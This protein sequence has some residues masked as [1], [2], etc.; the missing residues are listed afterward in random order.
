MALGMSLG[1][2]FGLLSRFALI[3]FALWCAFPAFARQEGAWRPRVAWEGD[4]KRATLNVNGVVV[5][6]FRPKTPSSEAEAD[7]FIR[8][9]FDFVTPME[10]AMLIADRLQEALD[11]G[12]KAAA[13]PTIRVDWRTEANSPRIKANGVMIA[14]ISAEAVSDAL[15][16]KA[17]KKAIAAAQTRALG[18]IEV[19]AA[20]LRRALAIPGLAV[21]GEAGRLVPMGEKKEFRLRGAA[22]GP[23]TVTT[24]RGGDTAIVA[25]SADEA[26]GTIRVTGVRPGR[27]VV[28]V[29]REGAIVRL[30]P[31]VKPYAATLNT[32]R[33]VE[34]TGALVPASHIIALTRA[35]A[36]DC[37]T[38]TPGAKITVPEGGFPVAALAAGRGQSVSVPVRV[39]GPEMLTVERKVFVPIVNRPTPFAKVATLLYSNNPESL[40]GPQRL[41]YA[42]LPEFKEGAA[43][44][45][46]HHQNKSGKSLRFSVELQNE[47]DAPAKVLLTGGDAGPA[48]DTV[49]VGY[50]AGAD[51]VDAQENRVGVWLELPPHSRMI[52]SD[53]RLPDA[54]TISGLMQF[55][56]LSGPPPLVKVTVEEQSASA[57]IA[58]LALP[59]AAQRIAA[60]PTPP[61][62]LSPHVY[63]EP[64][65]RLKAE[66]AVGGRWTFVPFGKKPR[67]SVAAGKATLYGDYG[68]TYEIAF[69]LTNPTTAAATARVVFEPSA[70]LAGG[71]FLVAEQQ[72]E[73]R[74]EIPRTDMP[75]ETALGSYRLAPGETRD[76]RIRTLPLSGSNYPAT[77]I[78][79]P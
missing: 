42:R 1:N 45:L 60:S 70:G 75:T 78:V 36:M 50:R 44:L 30:F 71:V 11:A 5:M 32:P 38:L 34:V 35:A 61:A 20:N 52:L 31:V 66:Y 8:P 54:L 49:W 53:L 18:Q 69:R 47:A 41:F 2:R 57:E 26:T 72:R 27:D 46:Y 43:R 65:E 48:R 23:I 28:T 24:E 39:T 77:L 9:E 74:V 58:F 3:A 64:L 12:A 7:G 4:D 62:F 73:R 33:T 56:V 55:R 16:G 22:R 40:T 67:P 29:E 19:W 21:V 14:S 59:L 13:V 63:A 51:F 37:A 6:G 79:R 17:R 15:H 76:I 25:A 68:V 10:R